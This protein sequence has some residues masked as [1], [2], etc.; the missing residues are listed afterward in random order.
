MRRCVVEQPREARSASSLSGAPFG[1]VQNHT[2]RRAETIGRSIA[3]VY[4]MRHIRRM[5][6]GSQSHLLLCS[7]GH[8]YVVKFQNNPQGCRTLACELL[9]ASIG[10]PTQQ[11]QV[12]EVTEKLIRRSPGLAIQLERGRQA[13]APGRCF[14]SRYPETGAGA[15]ADCATSALDLSAG[16]CS[17]VSN[18]ADC[19]GILVFDQWTCN[20]DARQLLFSLPDRGYPWHISMIDQ[21]SCFNGKRW[22]FPDSPLWGLYHGLEPHLGTEKLDAFEP[23][24]QKV[25]Q[26]IDARSIEAVAEQV[27][28][29]WYGDDGGAVNQLIEELDRRRSRLRE[30]IEVIARTLSRGLVRAPTVNV[31]DGTWRFYINFGGFRTM[32]RPGLQIVR[33]AAA[34]ERVATTVR[35]TADGGANR[36]G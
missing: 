1:R 15:I 34:P 11:P 19:L 31:P 26:A 18:L 8:H 29:E 16:A 23:W 14:G 33:A 2:N 32:P 9:A 4:G 6:G 10:L 12:I 13:C 21:G 5:P 17:Y 36:S 7:D 27:P 3:P 30:L 24:I 25:E 20:T 35:E 28:P 22:N